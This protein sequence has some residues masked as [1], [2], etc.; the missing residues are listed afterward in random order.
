MGDRPNK[1]IGLLS[2]RY[3]GLSPGS[4]ARSQWFAGD[5]IGGGEGGFEGLTPRRGRAR[6]IVKTLYNSAE[7]ARYSTATIEGGWRG[8]WN[9]RQKQRKVE[10]E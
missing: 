2:E 10:K 5:D 3:T 6:K 9:E 1:F 8:G 7:G 4:R